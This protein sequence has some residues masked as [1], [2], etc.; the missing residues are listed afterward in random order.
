MDL[1]KIKIIEERLEQ[2]EQAAECIKAL[3]H[4][5]RIRILQELKTGRKC[6]SELS[7]IVGVAQTNI[8]QHLS[9]LRNYGWI[10]KKKK[11]LYVYYSLSNENISF[12]LKKVCEITTSFK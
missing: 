3:T 4:P 7:E 5:V 8:S 2:L 6:V 11:A 9:L 1:D 10:T 12:V